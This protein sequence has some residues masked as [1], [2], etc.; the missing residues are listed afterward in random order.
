MQRFMLKAK[1][2][3]ATVTDAD[4]HYEGSISIDEKLLDEAGMLLYEKV[5]IYD[6]NNGERFSTYII[7]GKRNSGTICLNGAAARKVAKGDLIIIATYV[8]TDDKEAKNWKPK[9]VFV[10][11]KDKIKKLK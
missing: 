5:E 2:H 1:I 8:L 3:R 4:L 11:A 7:K 6:V 9:C 10:G